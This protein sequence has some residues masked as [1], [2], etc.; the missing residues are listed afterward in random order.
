MTRYT[1]RDFL[2][3]STVA[4][5]GVLAAACAKTEAPTAT[6]EP[7]AAAATATPAPKAEAPTATPVAAAVWPRG[8]VPRN[9]TVIRMNGP[10]SSATWAC[11]TLTGPVIRTSRATPRSWRDHF[12]M[13]LSPTRP[14]PTWP[15]AMSTMTTPPN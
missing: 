12:T 1:R 8:D 7:K 2:R 10:K 6:P 9:R 13:Q 3:L 14:T 5:A 4:A 15:R 11:R